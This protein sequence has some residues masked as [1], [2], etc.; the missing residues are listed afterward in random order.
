METDSLRL[1]G[2]APALRGDHDQPLGDFAYREARSRVEGHPRHL[3]SGGFDSYPLCPTP[4]L[5]R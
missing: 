1:G 4:S 2:T 5:E 3:L